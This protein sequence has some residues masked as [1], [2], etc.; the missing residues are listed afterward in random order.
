MDILSQI[1]QSA[2]CEFKKVANT[3]G[4]VWKGP[5]P[6]CGGTDRFSIYPFEGDGQYICNQCKRSG[7]PI[8]FERDFNNL[9]F[10]E[11]A[12]K[13]GAYHKLQD[14]KP[15]QKKEKKAPVERTWEPRQTELP[16]STWLKKATQFTF[17]S[18]KYLMSG[19][20]K[21]HREYLNG[22]GIPN[23]TIKTARIGYNPSAVQYSLGSFGLIE[24]KDKAGASKTVWI[25]AGIIIPYFDQDQTGQIRRIRIRSDT[26]S[27]SGGNTY[28]LLTGGTTEYFLY[29]GCTTGRPTIVVESELDGWCVW[30]AAG[31]LI[32]VVAVGNTTTRPD[33]VAHHS[34]LSTSP[35]VLCAFDN[36][37]AGRKEYL[38][39]KDQFKA[40]WWGTPRGKDPGEAFILGVDMR[41]WVEEA[42][43]GLDKPSQQ[44]VSY[45]FPEPGP[46]DQA[47][48][49]ED[50][51]LFDLDE[52]PEETQL[53]PTQEQHGP[54]DNEIFSRVRVR[55][56][57]DVTVCRDGRTCI[58]TL[59]GKCLLTHEYILH[60]KVCPKEKWFL[61]VEGEGLEL[62]IKGPAITGKKGRLW[63]TD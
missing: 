56:T 46:T 44:K 37:D 52:E 54:A 12:E 57:S 43:Q 20:G 47:D 62:I 40:D 4:G 51:P 42:V 22:R 19:H 17:N 27:N 23:E 16:P 48:Q 31:D 15:D 39:W 21:Q 49:E 30:S 55:K 32:N 38:W 9:T 24:E 58:H 28:V 60:T 6:W 25:P 33:V 36:D 7:D 3:K 8:Q 26:E 10:R 14:E 2:T 29:P 5:C 34:I 61:W 35:R 59:E 1:R 13:L 63:K 53:D 50:Q 41:K 45:S 11:A 18:Y